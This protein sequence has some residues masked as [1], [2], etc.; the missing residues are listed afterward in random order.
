MD[1]KTAAVK[2]LPGD[3]SKYPGNRV[4]VINIITAWI[5]ATTDDALVDIPQANDALFDN[6]D[7]A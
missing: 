4:L 2:L 5:V 6:E 7:L 1:Y 3:W